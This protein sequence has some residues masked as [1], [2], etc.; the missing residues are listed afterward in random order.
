MCIRDSCQ[1]TMTTPALINRKICLKKKIDN[2][3]PENIDFFD[4]KEEPV[5][6]ESAIPDG[7]VLLKN[8]YVS[9]DAGSRV[10]LSGAKT[11]TDPVKPGDLCPGFGLGQ[12]LVSKSK[13]Y[14]PGDYVC[15]PTHWQTYCITNEG[16]LLKCR[17]PKGYPYLQ[18]FLGLYCQNGLSAYFGLKLRAKVQK[19]ETVVVSTAAGATGCVAVQLAKI[20]GCRVVG[21]AGSDYKCDLVTKYY[22]ADVCINYKKTPDMYKALK[23]HCPDGIDVYFDNVGGETLEAVLRNLSKFARVVMCG[24]ISSYTDYNNRPGIKSYTNLA[25]KG[26]S[27]LGLFFFDHMDEVEPGIR[28]LYKYAKEGKLKY[29]EDMLY[30]IENVPLGMQ[31]M[32]KGENEGK[33]LIKIDEPYRPPP[34]PCLQGD[35]LKQQP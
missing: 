12:V 16:F 13:M 22:G 30:G 1:D 4:L 20:W 28:E 6:P 24:A 29:K 18:H 32:F 27:M 35:G 2:T 8:I 23:E 7:H 11:Y 33:I 10:Y 9:I 3:F 19:G 26:A 15:G 14:Q 5:P 21:I 17:I 34:R 31:R 25:L